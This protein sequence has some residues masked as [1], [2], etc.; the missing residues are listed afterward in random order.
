MR[1][2]R[3]AWTSLPLDVDDVDKGPAGIRTGCLAV[4]PVDGRVFLGTNIGLLVYDGARLKR[5]RF[6]TVAVDPTPLDHL[7]KV[8]P[9]SIDRVPIGAV[10]VDPRGA[11]W[12]G[13]ALGLFRDDGQRTRIYT[14]FHGLASGW[15]AEVHA[16][17]NEVYVHCRVGGRGGYVQ[18]M[19]FEP[20]YT[21]AY[22]RRLTRVI[23]RISMPWSAIDL[24]TV[25]D[26]HLCLYRPRSQKQDASSRY[27]LPG[28]PS[29]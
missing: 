4:S 19:T 26:G 17:R 22:P 13:T 1:Y 27:E 12:A 11:I 15:V 6:S 3:G 5:Y 29:P 8:R 25:S 24:M 16:G 7:I 9:E 14:T 2:E 21:D 10:S 28:D 23:E 20:V 18:R